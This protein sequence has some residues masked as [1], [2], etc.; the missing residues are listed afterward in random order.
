MEHFHERGYP[1]PVND[2]VLHYQPQH[3]SEKVWQ[4][5]DTPNL[6]VRTNTKGFSK[7]RIDGRVQE[8][9]VRAG[10]YGVFKTG[11]ISV[12]LSVVIA[13]VE[14][15]RPETHTFH[16][17]IGETTITLQDVSVLW[18]L[19]IDGLPVTGVDV[20][21]TDVENQQLCLELLGFSPDA[22]DFEGDRLALKAIRRHIEAHPLNAASGE[23][24]V[25]QHAR[26]R[27]MQ[28]LG[29]VFADQSGMKVK[30]L[31]LPFLRDLDQAGT[32]SWGSA[33]LASLYR[34]MCKAAKKT[35]TGMAG[36]VLL[37]QLWAWERLPKLRPELNLPHTVAHVPD[38]EYLPLGPRGC[39]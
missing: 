27:L 15:W 3:R 34:E 11:R 9:L 21:M 38:E 1:G 5:P 25:L 10:F 7:G 39:L 35:V 20:S 33:V 18:G 16:L 37:I 8:L 30:L 4:D 13:F 17:P 14:R 24:E 22:G 32:Y 19:P 2:W 29:Y 28:L 36:P 31:Y 26:C 23:V 6:K 12:D